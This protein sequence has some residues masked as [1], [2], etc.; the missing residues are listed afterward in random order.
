MMRFFDKL[1]DKIRAFLSNYPIP[2]AIIGGV[3]IVLFWRGVWETADMLM[4]SHPVLGWIFFGPVQIVLS[5]LILMAI[6]LMVSAFIGHRILLSG[7]R[8][9]KKIEEQ[10]DVL[11]KKE[12]VTLEILREEIRALR[13]EIDRLK[14]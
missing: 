3:A 9:E 8:R 1:E 12:V 10:A 7:I 6:G 2:Y 14:Q 11:L 13:K 5:V 4:M